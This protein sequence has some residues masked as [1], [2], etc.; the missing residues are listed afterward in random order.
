MGSNPH[1]CLWMQIILAD[2]KGPAAIT[3]RSAG[4]TPE[5]NLRNSFHTGKKAYKHTTEG[6]TL[7]FEPRINVMRSP[8][9]WYQLAPQKRAYVLQIC[10]KKC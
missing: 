4:V 7:A 3:K 1:Q 9:H 5:V 10:N 2:Q 8:E 6:S